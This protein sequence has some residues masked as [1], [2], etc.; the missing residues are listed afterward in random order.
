MIKK[1]LCF[2]KRHKL[3]SQTCPFTG[4]TLLICNKCFSKI[5]S[6]KMKFN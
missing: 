5:H 3:E 2:I 4:I 1:F 6:S